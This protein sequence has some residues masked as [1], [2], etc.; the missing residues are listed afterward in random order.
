MK[1][2]KIIYLPLACL[3]GLIML[4]GQ[5]AADIRAMQQPAESI[6][7]ASPAKPVKV[8]WLTPEEAVARAIR[9]DH[10]QALLAY[11]DQL[12][13][14]KNALDQLGIGEYR[15][16]QSLQKL[17]GKAPAK[18][19]L[20]SYLH[21][22][23]EILFMLDDLLA[24]IDARLP[25]DKTMYEKARS[26]RA[27]EKIIPQAML[28]YWRAAGAKAVDNN[29]RQLIAKSQK[30]LEPFIYSKEA[31]YKSA[32]Q[33]LLNVVAN[34]KYLQQLN[35]NTI[36]AFTDS[37]GLAVKAAAQLR[38]NPKQA[39]P[40]PTFTFDSSSMDTM[41]FGNFAQLKPASLDNSKKYLR[42]ITANLSYD[43]KSA[44]D[45]NLK[46]W[47]AVGKNLAFDLFNLLDR[48]ERKL[49]LKQDAKQKSNQTHLIGSALLTRSRLA[50]AQFMLNKEQYARTKCLLD[51]QQ[52]LQQQSYPELGKTLP[53]KIKAIA[54]ETDLLA[55]TIQRFNYYAEL[56]ASFHALNQ[57]LDR[58]SLPYKL[59][60]Q[61]LPAIT[62]TIKSF[63]SVPAN[64]R[65][66]DFSC[67]QSAA[68]LAAQKAELENLKKQLATSNHKITQLNRQI[69][70]LKNPPKKKQ[71]AS[72]LSNDWL[73]KQ[74]GY[75]YTLQILSSSKLKSLESYAL[76]HKLGANAKIIR[77]KYKGKTLYNL[78]YGLYK[79][80]ELAFVGQFKLPE[81]IQNDNK[82]FIRRIK[83]LQGIAW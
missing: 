34:L 53:E 74:P 58:A 83:E 57:S 24:E 9:Q 21:E 28:L 63:F 40:V 65:T 15:V 79:D 29:I 7:Q 25:A 71:T 67:Y 20:T 64:N 42:S 49:L 68:Q 82:V 16:S 11:D 41:V 4:A 60:S 75:M 73:K 43:L 44:N 62:N 1:N 77:S 72:N 38:F 6:L 45:E 32:K 14:H 12:K 70:Q 18:S 46:P 69:K 5:V 31:Q 35:A 19:Q 30:L 51:N 76:K 52:A 80:K 17:Q 55:L 10:Q 22:T 26:V 13:A 3:T 78:L 2:K 8:S 36:K 61:S 48:L 27:N 39:M 81:A 54:L 66:N 50:Y 23:N 59:E 33:D 56:I 47:L 37:T